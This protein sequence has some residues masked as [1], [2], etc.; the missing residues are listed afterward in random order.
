MQILLSVNLPAHGPPPYG[1]GI[2]T[3]ANIFCHVHWSVL[4]IVPHKSHN[5]FQAELVVRLD[6]ERH[7][8]LKVVSHGIVEIF[9]HSAVDPVES[10]PYACIA[11]TCGAKIN[12]C[13]NITEAEVCIG[14]V[15]PSEVP[16]NSHYISS[17]NCLNRRVEYLVYLCRCD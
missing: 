4:V 9:T 8:V 15:I 10:C 16:C 7:S 2:R 13:I 17:I 11:E 12:R 1:I 5:I 3:C 6:P 14:A